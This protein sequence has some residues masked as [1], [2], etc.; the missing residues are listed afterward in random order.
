MQRSPHF[1]DSL[2]D[3]RDFAKQ[4]SLLEDLYGEDRLLARGETLLTNKE[5]YEQQPLALP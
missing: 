4:W 1:I 3:G 2:D 5:C